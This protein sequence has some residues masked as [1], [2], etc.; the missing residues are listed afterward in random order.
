VRLMIAMAF[1]AV[2]LIPAGAPSHAGNAPEFAAQQG[3]SSDLSS[4]KKK[5]AKKKAAKKEEYLRAVPSGPPGA[6]Q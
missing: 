3:T 5:K 2:M 4:T 6:K 1:A